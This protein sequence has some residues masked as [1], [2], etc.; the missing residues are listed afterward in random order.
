MFNR[1][2]SK[3]KKYGVFDS[4]SKG[5]SKKEYTSDSLPDV[6]SNRKHGKF[7]NPSKRNVSRHFTGIGKRRNIKRKGNRS[8]QKKSKKKRRK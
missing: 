1:K 2:T 6:G 5:R 8:K 7:S 3:T 4:N